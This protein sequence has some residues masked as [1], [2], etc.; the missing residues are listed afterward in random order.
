[1]RGKNNGAAR[2]AVLERN[3][4]VFKIQVSFQKV[5]NHCLETE[6][7]KWGSRT[8]WI[9]EALPWEDKVKVTD[10]PALDEEQSGAGWECLPYSKVV[11]FI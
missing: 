4:K 10:W 1:M 5:R 9:W 6:E 3:R 2:E 8:T 7:D 11:L